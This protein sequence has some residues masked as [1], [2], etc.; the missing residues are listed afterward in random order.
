MNKPA[1]LWVLGVPLQESL[2]LSPA[3]AEKIA[4]CDLVIGESRKA[5]FRILAQVP[6][7][8]TK[9]LFLL[10]ESARPEEKEW[11]PAIKALKQSGGTAVLFSDTGM[12]LLFDPGRDVVEKCRAMGFEIHTRSG[13][14]SWGTACALTAWEPPFLVCGFPPREDRPRAAFFSNLRQSS[15]HCVLMERPYQF[16]GLL[17]ECRQTFGKQRPAFLAWELE[18]ENER[19]IWGTIEEL[20]KAARSFE[21]TKGEFIVVIK[22][23]PFPKN[24]SS[25]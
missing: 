8:K 2:G 6:G 13:P 7:A 18:S 9:P 19:L 10:D 1:T 15:A 23:L 14:T 3:T 25:S 24:A 17:E 4:A 21:K 5:S 12:P 22:G 11:E 16:L 20:E